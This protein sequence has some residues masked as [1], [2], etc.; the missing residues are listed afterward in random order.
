MDI[1]VNFTVKSKRLSNGVIVNIYLNYVKNNPNKSGGI[2]E[3]LVVEVKIS[4]FE[5]N[6]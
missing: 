6:K 5:N 1:N 2:L 4:Y 3:C